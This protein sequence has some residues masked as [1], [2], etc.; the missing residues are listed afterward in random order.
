MRGKLKALGPSIHFKSQ[1]GPGPLSSSP[2]PTKTGQAWRGRSW[3]L[4]LLWREGDNESSSAEPAGVWL[5]RNAEEIH[6]APDF[7]FS[8][9]AEVEQGWEVSREGLSWVPS[10]FILPTPPAPACPGT[11]KYTPS[12]PSK[13]LADSLHKQGVGFSLS[14]LCFGCKPSCTTALCKS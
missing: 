9:L 6:S 2:P 3:V 4:T 13:C 10:R 14:W 12:H 7:Y 1:G 8:Q 11:S 5:G